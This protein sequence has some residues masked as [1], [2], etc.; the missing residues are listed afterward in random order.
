M[1]HRTLGCLVRQAEVLH[2]Y[3]LKPHRPVQLSL[4]LRI[5]SELVKV[6][7]RQPFGSVDRMMGP[8]PHE[9]SEGPV[10]LKADLLSLEA[11]S[12]GWDSIAEPRPNV[13]GALQ[14]MQNRWCE[15]A[16]A[17]LGPL[18]G[19]AEVPCQSFDFKEVPL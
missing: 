14:V 16:R 3:D 11:G 6:R 4:G 18:C 1:V 15:L 12:G 2:E 10:S 19:M 13:M 17:Q 5:G 9:D 8:M 7:R